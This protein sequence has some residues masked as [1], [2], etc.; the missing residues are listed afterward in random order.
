M[1]RSTE[2]TPFP[3][4]GVTTQLAQF[5]KLSRASV[6][7]SA[8]PGLLSMQTVLGHVMQVDPMAAL[9]ARCGKGSGGTSGPARWG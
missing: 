6:A 1:I 3:R 8:G 2:I 5:H 7:G 4:G 9:K